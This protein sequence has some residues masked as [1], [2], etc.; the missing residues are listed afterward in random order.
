MGAALAGC[1][2]DSETVSGCFSS[3]L[4][5][6]SG[7]F[8]GRPYLKGER[9]WVGGFENPY[10]L[11]LTSHC[12]SQIVEWVIGTWLVMNHPP[13]PRLGGAAGQRERRGWLAW[14]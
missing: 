5:R 10:D 13:L 1:E 4:H 3:V 7:S 11:V 6:K 2:G 12:S 8:V 14:P 9:G